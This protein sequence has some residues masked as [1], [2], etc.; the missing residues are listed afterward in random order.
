MSKRIEDAFNALTNLGP[1][2]GKFKIGAPSGEK[3]TISP[4]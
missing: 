2:N 1:R 3:N 4:T